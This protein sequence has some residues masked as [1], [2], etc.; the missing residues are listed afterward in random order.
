MS[1]APCRAP[2]AI[3]RACSQWLHSARRRQIRPASL[4]TLLWLIFIA[5]MF[6]IGL[7]NLPNIVESTLAR[8]GTYN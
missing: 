6:S 4:E 3:A 1:Q 7:I 8:A 2:K 5:I